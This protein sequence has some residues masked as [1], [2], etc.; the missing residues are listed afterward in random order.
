MTAG[1]GRSRRAPA[2]R[3]GALEAAVAAGVLV[4]VM[5]VVRLPSP[6]AETARTVV[7]GAVTS[8]L[9]A[10]GPATSRQARA[11][12]RFVEAR[13]WGAVALLWTPL[14][15]L[16]TPPVWVAPVVGAPVMT[17]F[18]WRSGVHGFRWS[19]AMVFRT[20][21]GAPVLSPT[22]GRVLADRG[23]RLV[24]AS[25]AHPTVHVILGPLVPVSALRSGERVTA[26]MVAGHAVG[27]SLSLAVTRHGYPVNPAGPSYLNLN[28]RR[29]L[30]GR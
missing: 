4:V 20:R 27:R 13:S 14:V 16:M 30:P 7:R 9:T 11:L 22:N 23:G 8:G 25:L 24:L 28:L 12:L 6:W 15:R 26:G 19:G 5:A 2:R 10:A 1:F 18:G 3:R 29:R 17:P 21:G